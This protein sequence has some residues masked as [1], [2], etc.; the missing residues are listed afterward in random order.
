MEKY[1]RTMLFHEG[2]KAPDGYGSE[3]DGS[4]RYESDRK[5]FVR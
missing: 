5:A 1:Y 3:R 4:R 2:R